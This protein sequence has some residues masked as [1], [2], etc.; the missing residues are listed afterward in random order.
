M[1]LNYT[2]VERIYDIE[3]KL[4]SISDLTSAQV[5]TFATDAEAEVNANLV[6]NYTVPVAGTVPLLEAIATDIAIYRILSRRVFTQ[7][8]LQDSGWVDRF[9]EARDMLSDLLKNK[10][11]LVDVN[12]KLITSRTDVAKV[13]SNVKSYLPTFHE[14]GTLDH[15][16]DPNKIDDLIDERDI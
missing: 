1:A 3:P 13:F 5:V 6:R 15:V 14:A 7:E 11:L 8:R 9:K 10:I 12:G 4:S 16:Q 2:N